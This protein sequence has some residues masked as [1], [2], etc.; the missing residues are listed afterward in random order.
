MPDEPRKHR[1]LAIEQVAEEL[2]VSN[3]ADAR[4]MFT[5][6]SLSWRCQ[7]FSSPFSARVQCQWFDVL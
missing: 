2:D 3:L 5:H 4:F 1:F 6:C 7:T